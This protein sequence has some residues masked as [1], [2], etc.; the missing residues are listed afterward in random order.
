[1]TPT[2]KVTTPL[3]LIAKMFKQME[4]IDDRFN[5]QLVLH[6]CDGGIAEIDKLEKNL[7]KKLKSV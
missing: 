1:M 6:F 2:E 7:T 5:G 4:I 3:S